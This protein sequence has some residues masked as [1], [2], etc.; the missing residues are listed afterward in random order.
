MQIDKKQIL[1]VIIEEVC[2]KLY[3]NTTPTAKPCESQ[4]VSLYFLTH[5]YLAMAIVAFLHVYEQFKTGKW[6]LL[7]AMLSVRNNDKNRLHIAVSFAAITAHI[8]NL[9]VLTQKM[10]SFKK[11]AVAFF[12]AFLY[13]PLFACINFPY[14]FPSSILGAL[15]SAYLLCV[16]CIY[17]SQSSKCHGFNTDAFLIDLPSILL[18]G[19]LVLL[20]LKKIYKCFKTG[21]FASQPIPK[22]LVKKYQVTY[23]KNKFC[24]L[25]EGKKE[26]NETFLSIL[27][28]KL[29]CRNFFGWLKKR[30]DSFI[31]F[32][33]EMV[34]AILIILLLMYYGAMVIK[35]IKPIIIAHWFPKSCVKQVLEKNSSNRFPL[36][37]QFFSSIKN[38][39]IYKYLYDKL[40]TSLD[41]LLNEISDNYETSINHYKS[42]FIPV[43]DLAAICT[44]VIYLLNIIF[45]L[46]SFQRHSKLIFAGK[47]KHGFKNDFR[48]DVLANYKFM[49]FLIANVMWGIVWLFLILFFLM[50]AI[51]LLHYVPK[52]TI[53][54]W[55]KKLAMIIVP[56]TVF[57]MVQFLLVRC[58]F[59]DKSLSLVSIYIKHLKIYH[60]LGYF[61]LFFNVILGI[62]SSLK[63][64][65]LA[66]LV[67]ILFMG[68]LDRSS[69]MFLELFD[70]GHRSYVGFLRVQAAYKNPI[71]RCFCQILLEPS[72][73]GDLSTPQDVTSLRRLNEDDSERKCLLS[74]SMSAAKKRWLLAYTLIHNNSLCKY[75]KST[76]SSK[77]QSFILEIA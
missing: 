15:F 16:E 22:S 31:D 9:I 33:T 43:Y 4:S 5:I 51:G 74:S 50:Y 47:D 57:A 68:R 60:L 55:V 34:S 49:G 67:T 35:Y 42:I 12:M 48:L 2:Q 28:Y 54:S 1:Y 21:N 46:D 45:F 3:Q 61:V 56:S 64:A 75:R 29:F 66:F 41:K 20:F 8:F 7:V 32:P 13:F 53:V 71:M 44:I 62:F 19:T 65:L 69:M 23:V 17:I 10:N 77:K 25:I 39:S 63:R 26:T 59:S 14:L 73:G 37:D 30:Y 38:Q 52:P 27:K 18:K 70:T 36:R 24:K 76:L 58:F 40:S 72:S 6:T 11:M